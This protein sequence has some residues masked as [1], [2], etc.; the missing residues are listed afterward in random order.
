MILERFQLSSWLAF[1]KPFR[2]FTFFTLHVVG[3]QMYDCIRQ[4]TQHYRQMTGPKSI[5]FMEQ[6]VLCWTCHLLFLGVYQPCCVIVFRSV[7]G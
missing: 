2:R 7:E 3:Q 6:H 4:E 5:Q 1:E